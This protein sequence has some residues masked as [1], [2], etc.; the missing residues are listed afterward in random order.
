MHKACSAAL[1]MALQLM[2]SM[3]YRS[4]ALALNSHATS[5]TCIV[6]KQHLLT[7]ALP[8]ADQH[9]QLSNTLKMVCK[10]SNTSTY[11]TGHTAPDLL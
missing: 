3:T 4:P 10:L 5:Y 1:I 11:S 2:Q 9:M 6:S 8:H 7:A